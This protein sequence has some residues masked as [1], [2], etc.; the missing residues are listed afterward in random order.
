[1]G[2]YL[3]KWDT[4]KQTAIWIFKSKIKEYVES[5]E[6]PQLRHL[7]SYA[8]YEI[9]IILSNEEDFPLENEIKKIKK[10]L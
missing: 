8:V 7:P 2:M 6:K 10:I 5:G 4:D 1:M 9:M 3:V